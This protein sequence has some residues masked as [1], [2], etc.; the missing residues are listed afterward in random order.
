[1]KPTVLA[2]DYDGTIARDDRVDPSVLDAI[3]ET[4]RRDIS[5][6]LV[7]GRRLDDLRR[8]AGDLRFVDGVVAE[9]GALLHFPG[10]GLTTTLA[11]PIPSEFVAH[12]RERGIPHQA[13]QCL[14]EADASAASRMLDAIRQLELP[15]ALLFNR[16]RVMALAQGISKA[17]GLSAA[18]KTLRRSPRNAVAVGDAENDHELLRLAEVGAAVEWG[19]ASLQAAAD[20]VIAGDG[21]RAVAGFIRRVASMARIPTPVRARRGLIKRAVS[22]RWVSVAAT[23]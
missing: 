17:T 5:V 2:L 21:P 9:N 14:V 23:C 15:I 10:G 13:G 16:S 3:A 4:R 11:P 7:T 6:M 22:S 1:V 20:V 12:L 18:L 19:S 8:V